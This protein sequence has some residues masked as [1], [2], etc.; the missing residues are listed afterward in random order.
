MGH[1]ALWTMCS[2]GP[3]VQTLAHAS[4]PDEIF[5][6]FVQPAT[7][8]MGPERHI[9]KFNQPKLDMRYGGIFARISA[10]ISF[11]GLL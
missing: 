8:P 4:S 11:A 9:T 2:G 7:A 6:I 10:V 5:A 3:A 1:L